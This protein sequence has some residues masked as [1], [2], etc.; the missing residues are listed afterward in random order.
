MDL[1]N[2]M[3]AY[4]DEIGCARKPTEGVGL[5]RPDLSN[6]TYGVTASA[7]EPHDRDQGPPAGRHFMKAASRAA[8]SYGSARKRRRV[9]ITPPRS[10]SR[11]GR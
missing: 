7:P 9:A 2:N 3:I 11:A 8:T 4:Y 5:L 10:T 1:K 6:A